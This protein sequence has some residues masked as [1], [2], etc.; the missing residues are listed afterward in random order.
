MRRQ[1]HEDTRDGITLIARLLKPSEIYRDFF[2]NSELFLSVWL[3]FPCPET[4]HDTATK[5]REELP[6]DDP[7]GSSTPW[8]SM[9]LTKIS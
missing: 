8:P 6:P 2:R 5:G 1:V 9:T 3:S 4:N 7:G